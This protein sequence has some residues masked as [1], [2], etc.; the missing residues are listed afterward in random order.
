MPGPA[1]V[2]IG[3]AQPGESRPRRAAV[4]PEYLSERPFEGVDTIYDVLLYS[5]RV[6]GTKD[7]FGWRDIVDT[8]TETEE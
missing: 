3:D 8:H 4:H 5:A 2:E 6:H 7:A 1:S